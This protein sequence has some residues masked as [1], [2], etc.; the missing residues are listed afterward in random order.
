MAA[1]SA[2]VLTAGGLANNSPAIKTLRW[3]ISPSGEMR[4]RVILLA[5]ALMCSGCMSTTIKPAISG[6]KAGDGNVNPTKF[7]EI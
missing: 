1:L 7:I 5:V 6:A 3:I 4:M 2:K